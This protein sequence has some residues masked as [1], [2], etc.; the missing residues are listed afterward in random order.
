MNFR[1]QVNCTFKK[2]SF[3]LIFQVCCDFE[4]SLVVNRTKSLSQDQVIRCSDLVVK[5]LKLCRHKGVIE[6]AGIAL[7]KIVDSLTLRGICEEW[8]DS[9]LE[10]VIYLIQY[11]GGATVSRKSA[12]LSLL[13]QNIVAN[14]RRPQK[15]IQF[16]SFFAL[17]LG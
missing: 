2:H 8:L 9:V 7:S 10:D 17:A 12:G 16:T 4:S 6:A 15:V 3:F 5:K 13:I 14:D 1:T 11:K